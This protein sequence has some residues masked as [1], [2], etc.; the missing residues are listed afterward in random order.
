[1]AIFARG[2][3]EPSNGASF[4]NFKNSLLNSFGDSYKISVIDLSGRVTSSAT[5]EYSAVDVNPTQ[6]FG[7][8]GNVTGAILQADSIGSYAPSVNSGVESLI[9]YFQESPEVTSCPSTKYVLAGY[10]QGA[11]VVGTALADERMEPYL[12]RIIYT[13]YFGDPKL[14]TN[15]DQDNPWLRGTAPIGTNGSLVGRNPYTPKPLKNSTGSWCS[16]NDVVCTSRL[17]LLFFGNDHSRVYRESGSYDAAAKEIVAKFNKSLEQG[18]AYKA[19]GVPRQDIVLALDISPSMR[20]SSGL[21]KIDDG[22]K[23]NY[24]HMV[25]RLFDGSCSAR[26]SVVGY[27]DGSPSRTLLNFTSSKLDVLRVFE[28]L[29]V[30]E[31]S[32][33]STVSANDPLE[34]LGRATSMTWR[35]GSDKAVLFLSNTSSQTSVYA[36]ANKQRVQSLFESLR[37]RG[38]ISVYAFPND[39]SKPDLTYETPTVADYLQPIIK[40]TAGS[41]RGLPGICAPGGCDYY[42]FNFNTITAMQSAP[43]YELATAVSSLRVKA[44]QPVALNAIDISS[45]AINDALQNSSVQYDWYLDCNYPSSISISSSQPSANYVF[46]KAQS[47]TAALKTSTPLQYC[48]LG[49]SETYNREHSEYVAYFN[50]EVLPADMPPNSVPGKIKNLSKVRYK[51]RITYKW[52][53]PSNASELGEMAYIIRDKDGNIVAVTKQPTLHIVDLPNKKYGPIINISTASTLSTGE[54]TSS[55]SVAMKYEGII[56]EIK[57]AQKNTSTTKID[58]NVRAANPGNYTPSSGYYLA[59][60]SRGSDIMVKNRPN[61]LLDAGGIPDP[62]GSSGYTKAKT[63]AWL[64]LTIIAVPLSILVA[65]SIRPITRLI[66]S[67]KK[68]K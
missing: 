61:P 51:D 25:D 11:Q 64:Q 16:I 68:F 29:K 45:G 15:K 27:G 26:V 44:G 19:C 41:S 35:D 20:T 22:T 54:G 46:N 8:F 13:A 53:P 67:L 33:V 6:G 2:S 23:P 50:L 12:E 14:Y 1:M 47:C 5:H 30:N 58:G 52:N 55:E 18:S 32:P 7:E 10:S 57:D 40:A 36:D 59:E 28:L 9:E 56:D 34:A 48:G 38:G 60:A 24:A 62:Q 4:Q 63:P 39:R 49:C 65:A 42:F 31:E 17:P 21:F 37:N 43:K 66:I 3:G